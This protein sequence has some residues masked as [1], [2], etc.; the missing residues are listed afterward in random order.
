MLIPTPALASGQR[1]VLGYWLTPTVDQARFSVEV[2]AGGMHCVFNMHI[3]R[4]FAGLNTCVSLEVDQVW[5]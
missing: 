4:Q 5:I 2:S 1:T 3:P